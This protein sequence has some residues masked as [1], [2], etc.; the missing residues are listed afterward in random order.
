M[1][2]TVEGV[3]QFDGDRRVLNLHPHPERSPGR[4]VHVAHG[5]LQLEHA[6]LGPASGR[7]PWHSTDQVLRSSRHE[8]VNCWRS[9]SKPNSCIACTGT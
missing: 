2:T 6:G 8:D 7:G 1:L 5:A 9:V 4:V 3:A